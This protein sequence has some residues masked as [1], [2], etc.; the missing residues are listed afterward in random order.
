MI[1]FWDP[2]VKRISRRLDGWKKALLSLGRRITLIQ[3]SMSHIPSYSFSLFKIPVSIASKIEKM[4]R[5]F[6]WSRTRER[7]KNHLIRWD[8]I[9]RPKDLGGLGFG[10]ISLRHHAFLESGCRG[11]L[12]RG[13][14]FGIRLLRVSMGH[15]LKDKMPT[16]W[17]DGR[18]DVFGRPLHKFFR[19][20]L[21]I[22]V[23]WWGMGREPVFGK[24]F[25]GVINLCAHFSLVYIELFL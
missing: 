2:V 17:L 5:D 21:H 24:I 12:G 22:L 4:Q 14:V 10:K 13:A 8:V 19:I 23:L 1:G 7:K 20:S 25:D 18:T 15:I 9:C 16:W 6:L 3:S 11:S